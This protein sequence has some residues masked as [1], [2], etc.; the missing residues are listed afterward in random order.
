MIGMYLHSRNKMFVVCL[1]I[2]FFH[3]NIGL[4]W[5][6]NVYLLRYYTGCNADRPEKL[7]INTLVKLIR[8]KLWTWYGY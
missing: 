5:S 8:K 7:K 2:V 1:N 3:N 4:V 6:V